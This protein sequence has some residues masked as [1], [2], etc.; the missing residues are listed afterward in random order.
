MR[1]REARRCVAEAKKRAWTEW[2]QNLRTVEGRNKIFRVA[3]QMKKD[4]TDILGTNFVKNDE[5][6]IE[7]EGERVR[8][9]WK[10]YFENLLNKENPNEFEEEPPVE[11]PIEEISLEEVRAA[12]KIMKPRK[13]AGPSGVTTDLLKFAGE[14]GV[15]ELLQIFQEIF[16]K[17][18]CPA[19]W[20]ESLTMLYIREKVIHCNAVNIEAC[21]CLNMP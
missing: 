18:E 1:K 12:I 16:Q 10:A 21:G 5:G 17:C 2:S 7:V 6:A 13:A 3:A 19:K 8:K 14:T 11:G 4:K 15:K 20:R 9:V